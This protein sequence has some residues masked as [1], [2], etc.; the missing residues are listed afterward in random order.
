MRAATFLFQFSTSLPFSFPLCKRKQPKRDYPTAKL[1]WTPL[2]DSLLRP[3]HFT[4][5]SPLL[6]H[7]IPI[8]HLPTTSKYFSDPLPLT[9]IT[10]FNDAIECIVAIGN[11]DPKATVIVYEEGWKRVAT[12]SE[13][14]QRRVASAFAAQHKASQTM[15]EDLDSWRDQNGR[16][17]HRAAAQL[18]F[19]LLRMHATR[20]WFY[21]REWPEKRSP[22]NK[23]KRKREKEW[24]KKWNAR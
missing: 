13:S 4:R 18:H 3:P 17:N 15:P 2:S 22:E 24:K 7:I 9:R 5:L 11:H 10:L 8:A 6:P 19:A 14:L 23:K 20:F 12:E 1:S 21:G 16:A